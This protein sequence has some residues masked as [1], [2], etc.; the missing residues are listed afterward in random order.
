M[1]SSSKNDKSDCI[2]IDFG[3]Y[4][5]SETLV[6]DLNKNSKNQLLKLNPDQMK[7]T[8]WDHVLDLII[9]NNKCVVL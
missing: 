9:K 4:P 3:I 6:K 1:S 8:D 2:I 5:S 7:P